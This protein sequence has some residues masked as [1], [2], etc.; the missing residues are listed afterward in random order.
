MSRRETGE[1]SSTKPNHIKPDET[2]SDAIRRE[3]RPDQ[4]KS[5]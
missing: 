1:V 5:N 2:R 4:I 3:I